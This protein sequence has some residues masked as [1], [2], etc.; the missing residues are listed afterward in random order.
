[1]A[2]VLAGAGLF[3]YSRVASDL[4]RSLD[5]TLRSRAQDLSA[6]VVRKDSLRRTTSP[7]VEHGETFAEVV[8]ADG[9]V[10]DS[11]PTIRN[12]P[13]LTSAQ[14]ERASR[15]PTFTDRSSV[16]GLDEPARLF[17]VPLELRGERLVL[18]V[19]ATKENRAE[20]LSSLRT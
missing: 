16:P 3:V 9:R 4:S 7:F 2:L 15:G 10:T 11:T 19:G 8:G 14:L 18:V 6:L 17:A 12:E 13:L 20:T 5:D 1:M